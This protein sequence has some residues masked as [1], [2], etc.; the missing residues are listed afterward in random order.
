MIRSFTLPTDKIT[1]LLIF[2]LAV[3]SSEF[4]V[5]FWF[6]KL[7]HCVCLFCSLVQ[8]CICPKNS[9]MKKEWALS[10]I[11]QSLAS[12]VQPRFILDMYQ[13][14]TSFFLFGN[15]W[16]TFAV[17]LKYRYA[18]F[19]DLLLLSVCTRKNICLCNRNYCFC[20]THLKGFSEPPQCVRYRTQ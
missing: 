5:S 12:L 1:R 15:V 11:L 6:P 9:K 4:H 18:I 20:L 16:N 10:Q 19:V 13:F 8:G 7:E 3:R 17:Y 14:Y 2:C